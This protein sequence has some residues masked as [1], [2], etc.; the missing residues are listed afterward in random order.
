MSTG[1]I[2]PVNFPAAI[3]PISDR[4]RVLLQQLDTRHRLVE[5]QTLMIAALRNQVADLKTAN[6]S[7]RSLVEPGEA[8][9]KVAEHWHNQ[10]G[11]RTVAAPVGKPNAML[12][13]EGRQALDELAFAHEENGDL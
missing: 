13:H 7:L 8:S 4:E 5:R 2:T 3:D 11:I 9:L 6:D 12:T 10:I 1:Q